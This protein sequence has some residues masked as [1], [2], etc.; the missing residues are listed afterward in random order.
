MSNKSVL[1][2][3]QQTIKLNKRGVNHVIITRENYMLT[4]SDDK[5]VSL[6]LY[7][8]D[9]GMF[10]F[11]SAITCPNKVKTVAYD[12]KRR[13]IYAG[14][15]MGAVCIIPLSSRLEM[16][17]QKVEKW[18]SR[19]CGYLIFLEHHDV[20]I[21]C[22]FDKRI[23][24]FD[25]IHSR[26]IYTGQLSTDFIRFMLYDDVGG[27]LYLGTH[28]STGIPVYAF[29]EPSQADRF[30]PVLA[31]RLG[32]PNT[33][34]GA[35]INH[36]A[37]VRWIELEPQSRYLFSCDHDG[38]VLVF[39][40][41]TPGQEAASSALGSFT[42]H[43]NMKVRAIQWDNDAKLLLTCGADGSICVWDVIKR[44]LVTSHN[45]HSD[46]VMG[47]R[48]LVLNRIAG[49]DLEKSDA[50]QGL[51]HSDPPPLSIKRMITWSKDKTIRLWRI[52]VK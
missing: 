35:N 10:E 50:S 31:F 36:R 47:M 39:H 43:A 41:G 4:A 12:H 11:S 14:L 23:T 13:V 49:I 2:E 40:A 38:K 30:P 52:I 33:E 9:T 1:F 21:T 27:K 29:E 22:G 18:H 5:R 3:P 42:G 51:D 15:F 44:A 6:F 20:I 28:E 46:E 45:M 48:F 37:P 17:L 16:V 32:D 19:E 8:Y 34:K 26:H 25:C 24:V 7:N